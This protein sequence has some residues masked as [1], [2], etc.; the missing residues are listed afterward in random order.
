MSSSLS[1]YL[2]EKLVGLKVFVFAGPQS[3]LLAESGLGK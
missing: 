1:R 2:V 3:N